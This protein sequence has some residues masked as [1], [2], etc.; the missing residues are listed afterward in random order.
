MVIV[1]Q[2]TPTE[3]SSTHNLK[4][5]FTL[6]SLMISGELSA[7]LGIHF[8][9]DIKLPLASMLGIISLLA[10]VNIWTWVQVHRGV[11][12]SDLAFFCHLCIDVFV[13]AGLLYYAGGATNPF[14][15]LFLIPLIIS[16]TVLSARATW[17]IAALSILCY[18][19]LMRFY[20][21]LGE[22]TYTHQNDSFSQ[23]VLGMWFGFVMSATMIAWIIVGMAGTLRNRDQALSQARENTLRDEKLVALGTLATGTAH[24]LGTPLATM[25]VVVRELERTDVPDKMHRKLHIL[26]DQINRCKTA[27]SAL[28]ASAGEARAENGRLVTV[29]YFLPDLITTWQQQRGHVPIDCDFSG[30][31]AEA[32]II[33]EPTL[34]QALINLL[35]NAADASRSPLAMS[36]R[37]ND[38]AVTITILDRGPGLQTQ[39]IECLDQPKSSEKAFGMGLGLFLAHATIQ[40]LNGEIT[41]TDRKG[42]GTCTN[43][44]IPLF[45]K[46]QN[47]A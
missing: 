37:W 22:H 26:T 34:T 27:L 25:A 39:V 47:H 19:L 31:N 14:A 35:N 24:E 28:S 2:P 11:L 6:R 8:L 9:L 12:V 40:R 10:L 33:N 3:L 38:C 42:G 18:S 21:P 15:W 7:I 44:R 45:T 29:K 5:L 23:H 32:T 13:I 17:S 4:R 36:A 20:I 1:S 16:A 30:S 43:I 41:L 46:R